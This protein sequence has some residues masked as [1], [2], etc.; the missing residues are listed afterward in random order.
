MKKE[1]NSCGERKKEIQR[2]FVDRDEGSI[3][4]GYDSHG[5]S[6]AYRKRRGR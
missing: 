5:S 2:N 3:D 4:K 1:Y 6:R